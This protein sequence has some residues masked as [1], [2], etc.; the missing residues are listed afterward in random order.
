MIIAAS[1]SRTL[2]AGLFLLT[3]VVLN[4]A[5]RMLSPFLPA[6]GRN[7]G[8]DLATITLAVSFSMT[9]SAAG[10]FLTT[11]TERLGRKFS[12]GLGMLIFFL[13]AALVAVLP[14]YAAFVAG[15][16]LINLGDNLAT[17]SIQA[18]LSDHAPASERGKVL[19]ISELS[20]AL[21]FIVGVPFIGVILQRFGGQAPF[22]A[23]A[24]LAL[25]FLLLL[26]W[27]VP[28]DRRAASQQRR[29]A[30]GLRQVL[31]SRS[32]QAAMAISFF[33]L[34]GNQVVSLAFG[35]WL[36]D[37]FQLRLTQLGLAAVVIGLSDLCGEG[38][39][40]WV[41]DR[42]GRKGAVLAGL[43]ANSLMVLAF[44]LMV[45]TL[46]GA[47]VWLFLFF[48]SFEFAAVATLPLVADTMPSVPTTLMAANIAA[49]SAGIAVG[50]LLA[51][52]FYSFGFYANTWVTLLFNALAALMLTAVRLQP[53]TTAEE[54]VA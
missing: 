30:L 3:R 11:Y 26:I 13:G 8:V 40:A 41:L 39:G 44:P 21:A 43:V 6:F 24:F 14:T 7:L 28:S 36:E 23:L 10:P 9:T 19:A 45:V 16:L 52:V 4:T 18:Y 35:A 15:L 37:S 46:P 54:A 17:A 42:L 32:A 33:I 25:I 5:V 31:A 51:P 20:W 29:A 12:I 34:A 49:F 2:P 22:F 50:G 47:L 38:L 27:K 53:G 48:M 1:S